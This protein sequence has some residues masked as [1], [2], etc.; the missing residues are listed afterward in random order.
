MKCGECEHYSANNCRHQ[1]MDI[2][3]GMTCA[4]CVYVKRCTSIFGAKPENTKCDFEPIRFKAALGGETDVK[5][6]IN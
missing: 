1:C 3:E 6:N 4:D 5:G 2:P